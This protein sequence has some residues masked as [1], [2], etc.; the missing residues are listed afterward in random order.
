VAP[1]TDCRHELVPDVVLP[2]AFHRRGGDVLPRAAVPALL[3]D[4][5]AMEDARI[6]RHPEVLVPESGRGSGDLPPWVRAPIHPLG[7]GTLGDET[8]RS[9]DWPRQGWVRLCMAAQ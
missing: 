3:S 2:D 9:L 6:S 4:P 5:G 1:L 8:A 7:A